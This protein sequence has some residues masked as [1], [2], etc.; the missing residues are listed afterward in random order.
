[1]SHQ[2]IFP[3]AHSHLVKMLFFLKLIIRIEDNSPVIKRSI[4]CVDGNEKAF[5]RAA[6][7]TGTFIITV[8][9]M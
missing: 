1:M 7:D 4:K 3:G 2:F 9:C 5:L 8:D 6:L